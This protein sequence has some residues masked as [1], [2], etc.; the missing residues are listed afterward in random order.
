[1]VI[2]HNRAIEAKAAVESLFCQTF[3]PLEVVF[4]DNASDPPITINTKN[5]GMLRQIRFNEFVGASVARNTAIGIAKGAYIAFIDDD[6]IA[7]ASWLEEIQKGIDAQYEILGGSIEPKF[8]ATPPDWWK[9][10]VF[11]WGV[12][13]G[14]AFSKEIWGGNMIFK[15][16]VFDKIG[17]FNSRIGR[18][19]GKL[20]GYEET[21]LIN[22][23]IACCKTLFITKAKVFHRVTASRM[24]IR[25][26][27]RWSY[28][29]GKTEKAVNGFKPI[30]TTVEIIIALIM[31][32]N[33]NKI[34]TKCKRIKRMAW[35][36]QLLG[37]LF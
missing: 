37:R 18:Q 9:S 15:R 19:S 1:V 34:A 3:K 25:Y 36:T 10:G 12:G 11:F 8:M 30:D 33:P 14:N 29:W 6:C 31:N 35:M 24:T 7:T 22:K 23:G 13:V 2:S 32:L 17:L 4:I 21:E 26:I 28:Y 5:V 27:L 16:E 20:L